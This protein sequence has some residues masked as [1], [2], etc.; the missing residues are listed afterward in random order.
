MEEGFGNNVPAIF[1]AEFKDGSVKMFKGADA[2]GLIMNPD[3]DA[4]TVLAPMA[5]GLR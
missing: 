2:T 5:G 1:H 4:I 3:V